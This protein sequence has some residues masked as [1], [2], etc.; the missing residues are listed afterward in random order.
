MLCISLVITTYDTARRNT[1]NCNFLLNI[2]QIN[3][4]PTYSVFS[5]MIEFAV[6]SEN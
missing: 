6:M 5:L 4:R 3:K 2:D 1:F